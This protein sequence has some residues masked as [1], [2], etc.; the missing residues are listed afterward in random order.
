MRVLA[1]KKSEISDETILRLVELD[2]K[3]ASSVHVKFAGPI[4]AAREVNG[5]ELPIGPANVND[6]ALETSFKPYQPRTFA[7]KLG[8]APAQLTAVNSQPV[9]LKYDL[10]AA[11]EDDT[12]STGGFD[13]KGNALPAEMLPAEVK[14]NGVD[15]HLAPAERTSPM[16]WWPRGRRSSCPAGDFNKVYVVAASD[17]GD[18]EATF[19]VGEHA[20][21]VDVEDW[22]GFI[23]QWDYSPMEAA[24]RRRSPWVVALASRCAR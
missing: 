23:G 4:T 10:A 2:G 21:K 19:Q 17:D 11:S 6:G 14:L 15:F 9:E 24:S 18:Q 20:A 12:Q 22:G 8:A 1:L 13:A 3:P 16:R 7:L 5:Q